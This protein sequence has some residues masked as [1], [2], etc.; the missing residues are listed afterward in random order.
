MNDFSVEI[1]SDLVNSLADNDDKLKKNIKRTRTMSPWVPQQPHTK[2]N[3][4]QVSDGFETH[5]GSSAT[6][7]PLQPLMFL[8]VAPPAQSTRAEMDAIRSV[9]QESERVVERL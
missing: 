2:T 6:R 4:K 7:W 9:L 3:Q 8:P 5:K 1:S